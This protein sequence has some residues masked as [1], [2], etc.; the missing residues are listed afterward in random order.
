MPSTPER[1]QRARAAKDYPSDLRA[2]AEPVR[3][4]LCHVRET[5]I[6]DSLVELFI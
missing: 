5:E 2:A 1:T 6:T 3:Y 4:T